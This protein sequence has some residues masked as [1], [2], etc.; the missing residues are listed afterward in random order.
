MGKS[1][2]AAIWLLLDWLEDPEW[3]ATI[4]ASVN[5]A[6]IK[7]NVFADMVRLHGE[8]ILP[9]PGECMDTEIRMPGTVGMGIKVT[10]IMNST[11]RQSIKGRGKLKARPT[12]HPVFGKT[13]RVRFFFDE[14]EDMPPNIW[15]QIDTLLV[16]RDKSRLAGQIRVY[17]AFNPKDPQSKV[18][19]MCQPKGGYTVIQP[20]TEQWVSEKGYNVF[21]LN[22]TQHENWIEGCRLTREGKTPVPVFNIRGMQTY[23]GALGVIKAARDDNDPEIWTKIYGMYAPQGTFKTAVNR[24][25]VN[26]M[27][28]E[29]IF[30]NEPVRFAGVDVALEENGDR[31]TFAAFRIGKAIGWIDS[32]GKKHLFEKEKIDIP[33]QW[34][35][36]G[37][38][39][40]QKSIKRRLV[41]QCDNV[42]ELDHGRTDD[43]VDT[44]IQQCNLFGVKPENLCVD[45]TGMGIPIHDRLVSTFGHVQGICFG[46]K[47]TEV[48]ILAESQ[49]T[50]EELY[51]RITSEVF[52]AVSEW[53]DAKILRFGKA[54]PDLALDELCSRR[55][56][57]GKSK[58]TC[59]ETK[60]EYKARAGKSPDL[61]DS[62]TI[63][64]HA[65]RMGYPS[66]PGIYDE[67]I[68]PEP[69]KER[70]FTDAKPTTYAEQYA[71]IIIDDGR[72]VNTPVDDESSVW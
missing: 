62:I 33:P 20:D 37:K 69:E 66:I 49:G 13:S 64:V 53:V 46:N 4:L 27:R 28:G 39:I 16:A 11:N 54:V 57:L 72:T 60:K 14:I 2:F 38:L 12:P 40:T 61:A 25:L 71:P 17:G 1:F 59:I 3:T 30:D 44:I 5:F 43:L 6:H 42:F 7:E 56:L 9:L 70:D 31:S 65:I 51:D 48:K 18:G 10:A 55:A 41:V 29:W 67:E 26:E 50:P 32:N 19:Q 45:R 23:E 22:F 63:G 47:A 35:A 52:F 8:S 34:N 21:R 36:K 15:P 58:K 68:K 24:V